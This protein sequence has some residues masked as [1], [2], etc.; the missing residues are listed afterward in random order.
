MTVAFLGTPAPDLAQH[1]EMC[2][3]VTGCGG[4]GTAFYEILPDSNMNL[5]FRFSSSGCR[6]VL[7][8][9]VTEKA[10]VEIHD[11]AD[12][13]CFRFRPGQALNLADVRPADLIDTC[14]DI[15]KIRGE[16]IGSLAD[17]LHSLPDPASRQLVMEELLRGS[18]PLVRD[19]R[20]RQAAALL[21]AH[22]G[23]FQVNELAAELG[24]HIR[25]LERLFLD[26]LGMTPKR[27]TRLIRFRHLFTRLHTGG[28][29]SFADLAY[30]CGFADQSHMIRDFKELTG[31]LPGETGSCDARRL[32][33]TPRT[34]IVHRYRP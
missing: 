16:S 34:R 21:D 3:S 7:M 25:S 19:E 23:R 17:R 13:F 31:R 28:F 5:V 22:G 2:W 20:C 12:Y 30:A 29:E 15:D 26:H 9:P 8:G 11:A 32:G 1:V 6:M 10:C 27:L 14:V 4:S 24:L 33:G 18:L